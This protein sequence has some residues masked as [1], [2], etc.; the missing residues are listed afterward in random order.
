[1]DRS[2]GGDRAAVARSS[3][4]PRAATGPSGVEGGGSAAT[5]PWEH[6]SITTRPRRQYL[7]FMGT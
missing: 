7:V 4:G 5:G 1:M 3:G 2:G 6:G